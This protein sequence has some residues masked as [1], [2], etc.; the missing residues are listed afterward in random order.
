MKN[1]YATLVKTFLS[2]MEKNWDIQVGYYSTDEKYAPSR[3]CVDTVWKDDVSKAGK[4]PLWLGFIYDHTSIHY[5]AL[6][7]DMATGEMEINGVKIGVIDRD[8]FGLLV[9][10]Y[11]KWYLDKWAWMYKNDMVPENCLG[12]HDEFN[13]F[14]TGNE[15]YHTDEGFWHPAFEGVQLRNNETGFRTIDFNG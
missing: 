7:I 14:L 5:K 13:S 1:Q 2:T 6:W 12:V 10:F 15:R 8:I 11:N 9:P 4:N 3:F